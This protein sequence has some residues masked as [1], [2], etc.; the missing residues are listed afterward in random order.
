MYFVFIYGNRRI[1]SVEIVLRRG[2]RRGGG[3]V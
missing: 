3:M 1:K 2:I